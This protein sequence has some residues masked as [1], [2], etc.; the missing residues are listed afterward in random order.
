[1]HNSGLDDVLPLVF[2]RHLNQQAKL[3]MVLLRSSV[4][5]LGIQPLL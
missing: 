5:N 4:I 1:M 3:T 2:S